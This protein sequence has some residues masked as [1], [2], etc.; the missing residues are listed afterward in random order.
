MKK[1]FILLILLFTLLPGTIWSG[2]NK[3]EKSKIRCGSYVTVMRDMFS[4]YYQLDNGKVY[5]EI[6]GIKLIAHIPDDAAGV[7]VYARTLDMKYGYV[8]Y[9]VFPDYTP[10][11]SRDEKNLKINPLFMKT[12]PERNQPSGYII[13]FINLD[14]YAS[15]DGVEAK[16]IEAF[17]ITIEVIIDK[18]LVEC[19]YSKLKG[20][21]TIEEFKI[22]TYEDKPEDS[23]TLEASVRADSADK[24]TFPITRWPINDKMVGCGE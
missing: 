12:P 11:D 7:K 22:Y 15:E 24:L 19:V 17:E 23:W 18:K 13:P 6:A 4:E 21:R 9:E 8:H 20:D 5:S 1:R 10:R 3:D 16:A 2:G 14:I